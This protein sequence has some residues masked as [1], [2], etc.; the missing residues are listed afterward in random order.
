MFLVL[1]ILLLWFVGT[2]LISNDGVQYLSTAANIASGNGISTSVLYFDQH[3]QSGDI[4]SPQA[5]WPPV[6]P[7]FLSILSHFGENFHFTSVVLNL[8]LHGLSGLL[9]YRLLLR[10]GASV[11]VSLVIVA[12]FFLFTQGWV[13]ALEIRSE[14][15]FIL[16]VLIGMHLLPDQVDHGKTIWFWVG[17]TIGVAIAIRYVAVLMLGAA[18]FMLFLNCIRA[19]HASDR[20]TFKRI[21]VNGSLLACGALL[22]VVPTLVRNYRFSGSLL[23]RSG[24]DDGM[25]FIQMVALH[26]ETLVSF[27]GFYEGGALMNGLRHV[28]FIIL[29]M[30]FV[31]LFFHQCMTRSHRQDLKSVIVYS[32]WCTVFSIGFFIWTEL[33]TTTT[34]FNARYLSVI[35]LVAI[36]VFCWAGFCGQPDGE[37]NRKIMAHP[38]YR[39]LIFVVAAIFLIGQANAALSSVRLIEHQNNLSQL[40]GET[41]SDGL[42]L[43]EI[44]RKCTTDGQSLLS[45][46]AQQTHRFLKVPTVGVAQSFYTSYRFDAERA[47]DLIQQYRIS[48]MI[49]HTRDFDFRWPIDDEAKAHLMDVIDYFKAEDSFDTIFDDGTTVV[50]RNSKL[51]ET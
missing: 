46:Q 10:I 34:T 45:N 23:P 36:P 16:T 28:M 51:C 40:L 29:M 31:A 13:N 25:S 41:T 21:I 43:Y 32:F 44:A 3:F 19:L 42:P 48:L 5:M 37:V 18:L 24:L 9:L 12:T 47:G 14:S 15:L 1:S 30:S 27:L 49:L 7:L 38:L 20:S 33:S 2:D 8:L 50:L 17:I 4:P 35:L 22:I 39:S 11:S 26:V 6:F